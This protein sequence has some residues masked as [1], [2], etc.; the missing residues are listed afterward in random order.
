MTDTPAETRPA[1]NGSPAPARQT[2]DGVAAIAGMLPQVPQAVAE[3]VA[4]ILR[5]VQVQTRQHLCAQCVI[6]RIGW[7]AV[8]GRELKAAIAAAGAAFGLAEGDPRAGQLDD[9]KTLFFH[10]V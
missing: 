6:V 2:A 8:H 1:F 10:F 4:M 9:F 3:A 5:Q 7:E